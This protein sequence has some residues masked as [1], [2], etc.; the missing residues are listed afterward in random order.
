MR[1]NHAGNIP[2]KSLSHNI[3]DPKSSMLLLLS[4]LDDPRLKKV[5]RKSPLH[6]AFLQAIGVPNEGKELTVDNFSRLLDTRPAKVVK[7]MKDIQKA[8]FG[9][10]FAG[11]R[12]RL[13]RLIWSWGSTAQA[14]APRTRASEAPS[15]GRSVPSAAAEAPLQSLRRPDDHSDGLHRIDYRLR[16]DFGVEIVLPADISAEEAERL[17]KFILALPAKS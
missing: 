9:R 3:L 14:P 4:L 15:L 5:A 6:K 17:S 2:D 13:S 12:G 16:K 10:F 11:R 8:G 7:V 1:P